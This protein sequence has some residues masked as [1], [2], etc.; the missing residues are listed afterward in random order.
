MVN[1]Q[2]P[3]VVLQD[4]CALAFAAEH[5]ISGRPLNSYFDSD[6][7]EALGLHGWCLHVSLAPSRGPTV[8]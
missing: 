7:R 3:A 8:S 5:A 4:I 6:S 2:D 1:F